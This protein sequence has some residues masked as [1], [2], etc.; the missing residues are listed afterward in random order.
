MAYGTPLSL[1]E[2]VVSRKHGLEVRVPL[3]VRN[4]VQGGAH[5]VIKA[6]VGGRTLSYNMSDLAI[7][8]RH[9][10]LMTYDMGRN[11]AMANTIQNVAM[12]L[13]FGKVGM[14]VM[15][16]CNE[17]GIGAFFRKWGEKGAWQ[18]MAEA[19]QETGYELGKDVCFGVDGAADRYYRGN[20]VYELD[21]RNFDS[22]Q[23]MDYYGEMVEE[24]PILYTEDLFASS[25]DA[26]RHWSD[27]T[28]R[29]GHRLFVSLDD[30]ATTNARLIRPLIEARAGNMLL[31]KMNQI[32]TMLEGWR[33]AET[34]HKAGLTTIS[35]HRSTSSVDYMEIEV[36]LAL[37]MVRENMGRCIFAK[38]G[39]AKLIERA[40][41]YAM[42]QQWVEDWESEV[43]LCDPIRGEEKI[44]FFKG[45]PAPLNTGDLTLGVRVG[46]SNGLELNAVVPAG[47]STGETEACL[48]PV[49]D[50]VSNVNQLTEAMGLV[51]MAVGALPDQVTLTHRLLELEMKEALRLGHISRADSFEKLQE[52]AEMKRAL[53]ANS[54]LGLSVAFNRLR[55]AI[56]GKPS[57]LT[58]REVGEEMNRNGTT[59]D[60]EAFYTPVIRAIKA[61]PREPKPHTVFGA[62]SRET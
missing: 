21:G 18:V 17:G 4:T 22:R 59:F 60:D 32:G 37:S 6:K 38:C 43:A 16:T 55:A 13:I 15:G 9:L 57:W 20:G 28:E 44:I 48:V 33:A 50:A 51:G 2:P 42:A 47:T 11:Q 35:S 7:Q 12:N 41:R 27:F 39:G 26:W 53:G 24:Y 30:I 56:E 34:A 3:P 19:V 58:F 29:F 31:L 14:R 25:R 52:A 36:A 45:Y 40:M 10:I 1:P 8:E 62:A 23:L 49:G 61:G 46:L 54:L 5:G